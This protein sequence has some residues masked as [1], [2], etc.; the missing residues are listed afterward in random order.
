MWKAKTGRNDEQ[1]EIVQVRHEGAGADLDAADARYYITCCQTFTGERNIKT[2]TKRS[3]T[4]NR[5]ASKVEVEVVVSKVW[6]NTDR[7]WSSVELHALYKEKGQVDCNRSRLANSLKEILG[8]ETMMLLSPG[9]ANIL[10]SK[11]KATTALCL[12]RWTK[13]ILIC[14]WRQ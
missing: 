4:S 10:I 9:V 11:S 6:A 1:A 12:A 8:D 13:T 5:L 2:G 3:V 7:M 14:K